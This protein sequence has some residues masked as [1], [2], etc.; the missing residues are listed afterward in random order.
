MYGGVRKKGN[1]RGAT[2]A[3]SVQAAMTAERWGGVQDAQ[4]VEGGMRIIFVLGSEGGVW[5]GILEGVGGGG[6]G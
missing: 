5:G 2:H 4:V 6:G 3:A 1:V